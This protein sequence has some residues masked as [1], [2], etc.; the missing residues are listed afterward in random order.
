MICE[1]HEND[2][3]SGNHAAS[4]KKISPLVFTVSEPPAS[5]LQVQQQKIGR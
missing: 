3:N 5:S 2:Q 1:V 4:L